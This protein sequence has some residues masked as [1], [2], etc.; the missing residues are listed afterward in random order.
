[1]KNTKFVMQ[2]SS[3]T[4]HIDRPGSAFVWRNRTAGIMAAYSVHN[5]REEIWDAL[6]TCDI[7]GSQLLKIR[8]NV[9]FDDQMALGRWI[10]CTSPLVIN[11][12]VMSTFQG[13]DGSGKSMCPYLYDENELDYPISDIWIIKKDV[14]K[15]RPWCKIVNHVRPNEDIIALSFSDPD[16]SMPR[17]PAKSF[18]LPD[19]FISNIVLP[20]A[21]ALRVFIV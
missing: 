9:R 12:S 16:V 7:F 1:M 13:I 3:D 5:T 6:D 8:A 20:F 11:I 10:N 17:R 18:N 2:M 19:S 14:E 15:G 4:H 21:V